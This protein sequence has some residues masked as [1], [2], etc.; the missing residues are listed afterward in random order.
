[1]YKKTR[2]IR[3]NNGSSIEFDYERRGHRAYIGQ[4][5]SYVLCS[6]CN[7]HSIKMWNSLL[8][9]CWPTE[10]D[11][12]TPQV[13][14]LG[15]ADWNSDD[16]A[17]WE[18][19]ANPLASEPSVKVWWFPAKHIPLLTCSGASLLNAHGLSEPDETL[20]EYSYCE[21]VNPGWTSVW[22]DAMSTPDFDTYLREL[23][24][25][26]EKYYNNILHKTKEEN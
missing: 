20:G 11:T 1:M 23:I 22:D 10:R 13:W 12:I 24:G 19:V 2:T 16:T 9:V 7:Y 15:Y 5:P 26:S 3:F 4:Q 17:W 14:M 21:S 6:D 18:G 8:P 25:V